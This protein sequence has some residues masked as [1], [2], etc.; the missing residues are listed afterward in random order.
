MG[1]LGEYFSKSKNDIVELIDNKGTTEQFPREYLGCSQ[2]GE[3]CYRKL[4][5]YFRHVKKST[6][7]GRLNRLFKVGHKAE[8]DMI[9][10]LESIGIK[11]WD[12]LDSQAGFSGIGDHFRGHSDGACNNIPGSEKTTHLLEFKTA[13]KKSFAEMKKKG[14]KESKPTHYAQMCI[15]AYYAKFTR[16]LYMVYCKDDSSFYTER[17]HADNVFAKEL[18][19]K[20][21]QIITCEDVEEFPRIG[22]NSE[23]FYLCKWCDYSD[24]CFGHEKPEITCR[25]CSSVNIID[26]GKWECGLINRNIEL[27]LEDQHNACAN[28]NLLDCFLD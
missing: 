22:S 12:T 17:L 6:I 5:Y 9:K 23:S 8:A 20:A 10:A 13:N 21:E 28:Y 16:M 27:S 26:D 24:I 11:T 19:R 4:W 7:D 2:I 18:I 25:T 1:N 14:V 3:E 15:Y